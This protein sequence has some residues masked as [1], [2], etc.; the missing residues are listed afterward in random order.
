[1]TTSLFEKIGGEAAV[2]AAVKIF[3]HKVLDDPK[4]RHFF[5]ATDMEAQLAKQKNFLTYAF[6]GPIQ[7]KG[8][9]LR[10]AHAP[11]VKDGLNLGHFNVVVRHLRDT[12]EELGV[13]PLHI[14]MVMEI[15]ASTQEDVLGG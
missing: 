2:D 10:V 7:Y 1:M 5:V 12:L 3:Y 13:Q 15:V 6:G 14:D 8:K 4:V 9:S 11:M